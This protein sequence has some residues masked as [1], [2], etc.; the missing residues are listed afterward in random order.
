MST[1][2]RVTRHRCDWCAKAYA[3]RAYAQ[4]HEAKCSRNP[5]QRTC[6][7]CAHFSRTPCC[8]SAS[9]ECGCMGR[10]ECAVGAFVT[11]RFNDHETHAPDPNGWW[12]HVEDWR[13]DCPSWSGG[14]ER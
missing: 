9:D 6:S 4:R 14:T 10:N 13:R 1:A 12:T 11:W 5:A 8:A 7:T 3:S 2:V